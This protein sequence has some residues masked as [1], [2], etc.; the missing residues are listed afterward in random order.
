M[1]KSKTNYICNACGAVFKKWSGRCSECGR[2]DTIEEE[3][4]S[5]SQESLL[6][7]GK[8]QKIEY[9]DEE[10]QQ[11]PRI[12]SNIEE[13]DRV[14]GGGLVSGSVILLGGEPGIG[15]STILLQLASKLSSKSLDV[16]YVTGEE[17]PEQVKLRARRME[18]TGSNLKLITSNNTS[19][20]LAT[21]EE[22]KNVKMM[23]VD[24]IQTI[25]SSSSSSPPGTASQIRLA[26]GELSHYAKSKGV[27]LILVGHVTKEGQ[28]AGPKL[29]EHMVD[30]VMYFEGEDNSAEG[31]RLLRV[32]KNRF[33]NTGEIGVFEMQQQ[34]L[35]E[36]A[37]PSE[38]FLQSRDNSLS[39]VSVFAGIEGSRPMLM[40]I[41][42]LISPSN[43]ATPRRSVVGWDSNR[44][45][46]ITAVLGVRYGLNLGEYE[47]YLSVAGGLKISEPAAD[48]AV[49][50]SIIS[51][52]LDKPL[53][54]GSVIFG[55]IG[56]SG[57][58]RATSRINERLSEAY[59][60]GF[61]YFILPAGDNK[62]EL[63]KYP[64]CKALR[65][66]HVKDLNKLF[67]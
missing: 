58:V 61:R 18:V 52:A 43:L 25:Q 64:D 59:K 16:V 50:A 3:I 11:T 14:A 38:L 35:R 47:V 44:L 9:L 55:E 27:I 34:G 46:M 56:L 54:A 2:W 32:V 23:V 40:E 24:S 5:S 13:F 41:Q 7:Q 67:S 37:N 17:S 39:G 12:S 20:I 22:L 51:A 28:I 62:F 66:S 45:A 63:D 48:L 33:G 26:A 31:F 30:T 6:S 10:I 4:T 8:A 29:L 42:S 36:V 21:A 65:I 60:L 19:D 53:P 57:E 15:K 1:K 49:A